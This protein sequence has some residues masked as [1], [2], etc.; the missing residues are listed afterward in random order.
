MVDL[1]LCGPGQ[2]VVVITLSREHPVLTGIRFI[3]ELH[4]L[5][6][7]KRRIKRVA[8]GITKVSHSVYVRR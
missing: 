2:Y 5:G 1:L 3:V 7:R 4:A 8:G 6:S